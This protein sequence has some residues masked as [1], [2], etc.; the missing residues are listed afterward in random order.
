M[1]PTTAPRIVTRVLLV[2][3]V[4]A[5]AFWAGGKVKAFNP[6]PDPPGKAA[7]SVQDGELLRV[8]VS[9]LPPGPCAVQASFF[10]AEGMMIGDVQERRLMPGHSSFF[11]VFFQVGDVPFRHVRVELRSLPRGCATSN[12]QL[13]DM[14]TGKTLAIY[15][16]SPVL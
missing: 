12:M 13:M 7:L 8:N 9:N 1:K 15:A 11:D 6:Q 2:A 3:V 16:G 14:E 10:D 4:T 5:L